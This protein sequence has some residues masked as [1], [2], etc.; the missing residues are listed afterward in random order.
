MAMKK[1]ITIATA[2]GAAALAGCGGYG[3]YGISAPT[4]A[5]TLGPACV[6]PSGTQAALVYPAPGSTGVNDANGEV[7]IGST[8]ALPVGQSGENWEIVFSDA[9]YPNGAEL[10]ST[11]LAATTPPFPSPSQTPSFANPQYQQQTSGVP[12]AANQVVT[13]YL[14]N[15]ASSDNCAPLQIGQF[16]T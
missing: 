7:V 8:T 13:I 9:V 14:N 10:S 12:F 4:P 2:L 5:P 16:S 6:L 3:G 1:I 11:P 15:L